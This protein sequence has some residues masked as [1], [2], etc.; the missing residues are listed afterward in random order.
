MPGHFLYFRPFAFS[1][2]LDFEREREG[3]RSAPSRRASV[4]ACGRPL[5]LWPETSVFRADD[6]LAAT[7]HPKRQRAGAVHN[8]RM[9][10]APGGSNPRANR[11]L[12]RG[13][14]EQ[15]SNGGGARFLSRWRGHQQQPIPA[16][17][18][19]AVVK[20]RQSVPNL[21]VFDRACQRSAHHFAGAI[22]T[23][24]GWNSSTLP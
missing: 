12:L 18:R 23:R 19:R 24:A 15:T 3:C 13:S 6:E 22:L 5:P 16:A 17:N 2:V 11:N 4:V 14:L 1:N 7:P 20:L 9:E 8:L 21:T 10:S